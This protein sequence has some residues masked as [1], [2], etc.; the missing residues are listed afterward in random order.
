MTLVFKRVDKTKI[1]L[2]F[3]WR[4]K[5]RQSCG[6]TFCGNV[7]GAKGC[8]GGERCCSGTT[9]I[10]KSVGGSIARCKGAS[11]GI[12]IMKGDGDGVVRIGSCS[13]EKMSNTKKSY[14]FGKRN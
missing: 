2:D 6:V 10:H 11:D 7:N 13:E 14:T 12:S 3:H 9:T 5:G 8:K 1:S 4:I